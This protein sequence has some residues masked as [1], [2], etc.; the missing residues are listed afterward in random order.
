VPH[1]AAIVSVAESEGSATDFG[2]A[3]RS[4]EFTSS[5]EKAQMSVPAIFLTEVRGNTRSADRTIKPGQKSLVGRSES[6]E[7]ARRLPAAQ[8]QVSGQTNQD[9]NRS[10]KIAGDKRIEVFHG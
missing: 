1:V 6:R 5:D 4:A 10:S 9:G 2:G 3:A 8:R 7:R